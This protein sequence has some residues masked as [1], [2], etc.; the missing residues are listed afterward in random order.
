MNCKEVQDKLSAFLAAE[1][2]DQESLSLRSHLETCADCSYCCAQLE[3]LDEVIDEWKTENTS[4]E[5]LSNVLNK[6]HS[7]IYGNTLPADDILTPEDV[8]TFLKLP[9]ATVYEMSQQL[10][11]FYFGEHMRIRRESLLKWIE[12]EEAQARRRALAACVHSM[13]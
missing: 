5:V 6:I 9:V 7:N 12:E 1:L 2:D 4:T 8:A 11:F 10:P 3:K 13:K